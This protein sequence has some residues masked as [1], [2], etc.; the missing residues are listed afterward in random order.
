M[1]EGGFLDIFWGMNEDVMFFLGRYR[2]TIVDFEFLTQT[3]SQLR[4]AIHDAS[5]WTHPI[6][7]PKNV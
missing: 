3:R 2:Q 4:L 5:S 1:L 6:F 7:H